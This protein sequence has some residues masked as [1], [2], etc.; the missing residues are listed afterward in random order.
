MG[1]TQLHLPPT[2]LAWNGFAGWPLLLMIGQLA[3]QP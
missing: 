3:T 1:G 2:I